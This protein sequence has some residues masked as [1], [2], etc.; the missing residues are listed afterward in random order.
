MAHHAWTL[1]QGL[2]FEA[3]LQNIRVEESSRETLVSARP[4]V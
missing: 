1:P 2:E 3:P 4:G